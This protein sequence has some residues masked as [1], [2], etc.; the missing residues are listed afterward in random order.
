MKVHV[1]IAPSSWKHIFLNYSLH[2]PSP[3]PSPSLRSLSRKSS[4]ESLLETL[5]LFFRTVPEACH[6]CIHMYTYVAVPKMHKVV[7]VSLREWR[8]SENGIF[9]R[10]T[11][12]WCRDS[13]SKLM[14]W[15]F[16]T[17]VLIHV[18]HDAHRWDFSICWVHNFQRTGTIG[19]AFPLPASN[20]WLRAT[21]YKWRSSEYLRM[22][23]L[24]PSK[25]HHSARSPW[26]HYEHIYMCHTCALLHQ[27]CQANWLQEQD[28]ARQ[29]G[30]ANMH[31]IIGNRV[32]RIV[33][34]VIWKHPEGNT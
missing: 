8:G 12:T 17:S 14:S 19:T 28:G 16:K 2:H 6:I 20:A 5:S 33:R 21:V 27:N 15:H 31:W 13:S 4:F 18:I 29:T 26:N 22:K 9:M 10:F 25:S 24:N 30:F 7:T 32:K 3:V 23:Q 11:W 1:P 34:R